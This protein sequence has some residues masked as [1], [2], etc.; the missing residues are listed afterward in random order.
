MKS[1]TYEEF[2]EKFKPKKTTDD[3]YTPPEIYEV[4]KEWVCKRYG[5]DADQ[6]VRPFWPGADYQAAEYL[7]G[8]T[9]LDNSP[10]SILQKICA[11]YLERGI[12]FFLFAPSLTAFSGVLWESVNHIICDCNIV[13]ENGAEVRTSFITNLDESGII[14]ETSPELTKLVNDMSAKLRREKTRSLPKYSYPDHIVTAALMGKWTKY[15]VDFKVKRGECT[16]VRMLD[17]QKPEG[18]TIFGG[19]LLL[20]ERAAAE[21]AAA[22]RAA[23]VRYTL[24][25]REREIVRALG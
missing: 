18:K 2:V 14:A 10:F 7:D 15:G 12:K 6:I 11:W 8:C 24:S 4:I 19:G 16:R 9:V 20:S 3:C 25:D 1:K 21:R 13:Y 22:E 5:I 23:A 17:A